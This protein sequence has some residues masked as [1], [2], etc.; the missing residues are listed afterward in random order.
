MRVPALFALC[1][2]LG[3][4]ALFGR[5]DAVEGPEIDVVTLSMAE[6][7]NDG[8]PVRVELVRTDRADVLH[9]LLSTP[10]HEWFDAA[11]RAFENAYPA[12]RIDRWELVPGTQVGPVGVE[13]DDDAVAV[14]F[15]E[16]A[17]G[18]GPVRLAIGQHLAVRVTDEGCAV[19][20]AVH[21]R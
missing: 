11:A 18:S 15:C 21:G 1:A 12:V 2:L 10:S 19:R 7:A 14:L 9:R 3:G 4:C 20:L 16:L 5:G 8:W 17:P 6:G 13:I